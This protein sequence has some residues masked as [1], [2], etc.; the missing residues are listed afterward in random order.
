MNPDNESPEDAL[1]ALRE[2]LRVSPNNTALRQHLAEMLLS[3]GHAEEAAKEF[4]EALGIAP[5]SIP[6]KLGLAR[7]FY[8]EGKQS[9]ALVIIEDLVKNPNAPARAFLLHA[10]LLAGVG[11]IEKA[12]SEYRRAIELDKSVADLEFASR[13]GINAKESESEVVEGKVRAS[14]Q[15]EPAPAE[16]EI[17]RPKITFKDVGGMEK[18]K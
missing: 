9:H 1:Q 10:R 16:R 18:V 5:N 8:Q 2:A 3:H 17:E 13:L 6:L 12:V 14:W 4:R 15:D 11:E 7:A